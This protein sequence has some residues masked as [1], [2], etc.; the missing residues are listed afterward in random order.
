[1]PT[2]LE[3]EIVP[4]QPEG[5]T[6]IQLSKSTKRKLDVLKDELMD[7][8]DTFDDL[9]LELIERRTPSADEVDEDLGA[10]LLV[11]IESL[12]AV[13]QMLARDPKNGYLFRA[14]LA[15]WG[16][17]GKAGEREESF[18]D[19]RQCAGL[20]VKA[21]SEM[22]LCERD[23]DLPSEVKEVLVERERKMAVAKKVLNA[24]GGAAETK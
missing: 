2:T 22:S 12:E 3:K 1:M 21:P 7:D 18:F 15:E 11:R 6:S 10:Q 5:R 19:S 20:F 16:R 17:D 24:K 23:G 9:M 8:S 14:D 13:I 4:P